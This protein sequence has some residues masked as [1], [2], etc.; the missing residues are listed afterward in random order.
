MSFPSTD[1]AFSERLACR[2]RLLRLRFCRRLPPPGKT[3]FSGGTPSP[4]V[5]IAD[6]R[7]FRMRGFLTI[8][9]PSHSF[10]SDCL[11]TFSSGW[12]LSAPATSA[13]RA[14]Q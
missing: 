13:D 10:E 11:A 9:G 5:R 8:I 1:F 2:V 6:C 4:V 3:A 14:S 12:S 7:A